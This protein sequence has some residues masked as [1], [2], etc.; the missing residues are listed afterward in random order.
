MSLFC[1]VHG[2]T[3]HAACWDL[4][5][6][7]L[8]R[9]KH[10]TLRVQL[11]GDEPDASA[12]RYADVI[13]GVIPKERDDSSV[14]AHSA[15]GIF[16]PLVP[17]RCPVRQLVFLAAV[18]PLTGK[19]MVDQAKEDKTM[20]NPDWLGKDPTKDEQVARQFL[21]HDCTPETTEWALGTLRL[22]YAGQAL[23]ETCPLEV[24]PDV[25]C[26]YVLCQEDRTINPEWSRRVARERLGV[27]AIEL[28]GGHC[29]YL[30][31]PVELAEVLG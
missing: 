11:P 12:T 15:S 10:E 27:E 30:S 16:L 9:R 31:R 26:S 3:Q 8:E 4:L 21:F 6:P 24:W 19:S 2:S 20:L 22:M 1:L 23:L 17:E 14:V 13:A 5:V 25:P 28:E 18:V 7:E 29:P